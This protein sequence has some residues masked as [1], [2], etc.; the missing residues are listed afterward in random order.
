ML[1]ALIIKSGSLTQV[2]LDELSNGLQASKLICQYVPPPTGDAPEGEGS[3]S[4]T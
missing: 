1:S 3:G 2:N 4:R